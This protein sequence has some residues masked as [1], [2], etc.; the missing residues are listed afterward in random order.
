[1]GRKRPAAGALVAR[2]VAPPRVG[3]EDML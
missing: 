3:V 2:V 1:L